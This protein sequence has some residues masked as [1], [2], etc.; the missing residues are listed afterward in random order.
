M[1]DSDVWRKLSVEEGCSKQK[2]CCLAPKT[3]LILTTNQMPQR[4]CSFAGFA[5]SCEL[6]VARLSWKFFQMRHKHCATSFHIGEAIL[7]GVQDFSV[8]TMRKRKKMK[9]G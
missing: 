6:I 7:Q 2:L 8:T 3:S 9:D 5:P 1:K 4:S